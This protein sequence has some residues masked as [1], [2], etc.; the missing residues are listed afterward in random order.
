MTRATPTPS[1]NLA[2]LALL[3]AEIAR[4]EAARIPATGAGN[5]KLRAETLRVAE[6]AEAR[7]AREDSGARAARLIAA[8][9]QRVP[10]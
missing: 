4:E 9:A 2:G 7:A 1:T 3:V 10:A 8:A 5:A 6:Q